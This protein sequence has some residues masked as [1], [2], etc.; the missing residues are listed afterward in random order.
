MRFSRTSR[1]VSKHDFKF[2]FDKPRKA[3]SK[4]LQV[5][6]RPNTLSH[7][8]LGI[9]ISKLKARLSVDRNRVRRVVRE[10]F[11]QHQSTLGGVDVVVMLKSVLDKLDGKL[12]RDEIDNLWH[13]I[14][15]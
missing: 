9:V 5:L 11:R 15:H 2:V 13:S 6:Y 8:R 1:L 3:Y 7:A 10:S 14:T 4:H 12:L